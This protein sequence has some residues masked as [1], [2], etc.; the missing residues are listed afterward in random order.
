MRNL[1]LV[2]LLV[3]M[4]IV[5]GCP[6]SRIIRGSFRDGSGNLYSYLLEDDPKE[7]VAEVSVAYKGKEYRCQVK[8]TTDDPNLLEVDV[9]V[10]QADITGSVKVTY[11]KVSVHCSLLEV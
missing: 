5:A 6:T 11:K 3:T 1:V 4:F 10:S 8:Y 9:D 7:K 2:I